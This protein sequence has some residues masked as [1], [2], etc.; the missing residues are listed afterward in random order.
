VTDTR[1]RSVLLC[2]VSSELRVRPPQLQVADYCGVQ[3]TPLNVYTH[4]IDGVLR[5]AVDNVGSELFTL[6]R[7]PA[8]TMEPGGTKSSNAS[9]F[10]IMTV[11]HAVPE[12]ARTIDLGTSGTYASPT[13]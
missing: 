8:V 9:M 7:R 13:P 10:P 5:A 12:T 3:D 6:V 4:V 1:E 2:T 11:T